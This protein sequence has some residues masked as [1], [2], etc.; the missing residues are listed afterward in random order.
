MI[1]ITGNTNFYECVCMY[2]YTYLYILLIC[3]GYI[4]IKYIVKETRYLSAYIRM[5]IIR[6]TQIESL[7]TLFSQGT[8]LGSN[9]T[10]PTMQI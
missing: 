6:A 9:E 2:V 5:F 7:E 10:G 1:K 3:F 4:Y 8:V